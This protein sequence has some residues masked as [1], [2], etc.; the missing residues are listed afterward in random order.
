VLGRDV[1]MKVVGRK[2]LDDFVVRHS[3]MRSQADAWLCEVEEAEWQS[4]QDVKA[5]Y[6]HASFLSDSRV[7]FNLKGNKYR[8]EAKVSYATRIV[9]IVRIGTHAEYSKWSF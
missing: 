5:R 8:L 4:P 3:D 6:A 7:I 2:S 9:L 1:A